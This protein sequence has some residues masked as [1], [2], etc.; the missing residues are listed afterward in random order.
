M[1]KPNKPPALR[2]GDAIRVLSLASPAKEDCLQRGCEEIARLG[3][4]ARP[5]RPACWRGK[6]SSQDRLW[7]AVRLL[8]RPSAIPAHAQF[9][10]R[11]EVTARTICS[12]DWGRPAAAKI[13]MGA[14]EITSLQIFL[15]QKFRLGDL[16][17]PDGRR[18]LHQGAGAPHGYDASLLRALTETKAAGPSTCRA[19]RIDGPVNGPA[20]W[21]SSGRLPYA[22]R[23]SLGTPWELAYRRRDFGPG[24]P[25]HEALSNRSRTDAPQAG[26]KISTALKGSFSAIFRIATRPLA[27]RR[28][29]TLPGVFLGPSAFPS[30]GAR[31]LAIRRDPCSR[32]RWESVPNFMP[33][34]RAENS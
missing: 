28:C 34:R 27:M 10:V 1:H 12:T 3:F 9:F 7:L 33:E 21:H 18:Q 23:N 5:T 19:N 4:C 31:L 32:C 2:P 8:R 22:D 14:S 15:W 16:L 6:A 26:R 17:R 13:F 30:S 11:A 25:R 20:Q 24:R 29:T